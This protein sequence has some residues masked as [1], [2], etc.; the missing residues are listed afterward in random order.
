MTRLLAVSSDAV[1]VLD[2]ERRLLRFALADGGTSA[3]GDEQARIESHAA[4]PDR[5]YLLAS[6]PDR[7]ASL[8]TLALPECSTLWT[9]P[10]PQGID[11]RA[12]IAAPDGCG[13][14]LADRNQPPDR[15]FSLQRYARDGRMRQS[16][17]SD[18]S[19]QVTLLPDAVLSA[20]RDGLSV[21]LTPVDA[22]R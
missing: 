6:D 19:Q 16:F 8:I 22:P 2:E 1:L 18:G 17:A 20:G 4:T 9:Q 15:A 5:L 7:R 11:A 14:I 10:L 3:L 12:V 21:V 13:C